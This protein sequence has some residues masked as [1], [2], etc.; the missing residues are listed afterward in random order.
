MVFFSALNIRVTTLKSSLNL[1][2]GHSQALH[3]FLCLD[4]S[5][6]FLISGFVVVAETDFFCSNSGAGPPHPYQ[7]LVVICC[8][9][10]SWLDGGINR[11][12]LRTPHLRVPARP[13]P[14]PPPAVGS[15]CPCSSE[16]VPWACAV[17]LEWQEFLQASLLSVS[18]PDYIHQTPLNCWHSSK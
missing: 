11:F 17:T 16:G 7:L 5:F 10:S 9:S 2:S 6:L 13:L 18:V 4:H 15:Y 14:P 8:L 3:V 1:T 12:L